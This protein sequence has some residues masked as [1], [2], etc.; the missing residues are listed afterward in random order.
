MS[1]VSYFQSIAYSCV[2]EGSFIFCNITLPCKKHSLLKGPWILEVTFSY[3]Q[4]LNVLQG[5]ACKIFMKIA[6]ISLHSQV[7]FKYRCLRGEENIFLIR[8]LYG[9]WVTGSLGVR[10][11]L[12][13]CP[14]VSY[15]VHVI[16]VN[17]EHFKFQWKRYLMSPFLLIPH[18]NYY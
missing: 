10:E 1:K 7:S 2:P 14:W 3:M 9:S 8:K 15:S 5:H 4:L 12:N 6:P 13:Y 11:H 18:K 17:E 16:L